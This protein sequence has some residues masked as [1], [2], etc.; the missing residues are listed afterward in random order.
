MPG[1]VNHEYT[2]YVEGSKFSGKRGMKAGLRALPSIVHHI[3]HT[4][5]TTMHRIIISP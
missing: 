3:N 1:V 2:F 4:V 5:Y